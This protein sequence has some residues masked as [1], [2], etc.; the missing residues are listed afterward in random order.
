MPVTVPFFYSFINDPPVGGRW[1]LMTHVGQSDEDTVAF[2]DESRYMR[3]PGEVPVEN[4]AKI[5]HG[6]ALMDRVLS[7]PNGD[8]V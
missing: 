5:P 6:G 8:R 2:F 4:H 7:E 1:Y 3:V